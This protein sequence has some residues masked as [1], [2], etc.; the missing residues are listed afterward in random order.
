MAAVNPR[1]KL[2]GTKS[3]NAAQT[4]SAGVLVYLTDTKE[5]SMHDGSTPGGT[6]FRPTQC[7]PEG[8]LI[9]GIIAVAVA[10]NNLTVSIKTLAGNNP[11]AT[12]SVFVRIGTAIHEITAALSVTLA[13]G[14][15]W[16]G[17]GGTMFAGKTADLFV[18]LGYNAT[19][20]V[21]LGISR[22]PYATTYAEFSA[23]STAETYAG[24]STITH[25]ASTDSYCVVGRFAASL[26][27]SAT[28]YWTDG[29]TGTRGLIHRPIFETEVRTYTPTLSNFTIG[30][31]GNAAVTGTYRLSGK[32]VEIEASAVLGSSGQSV[33][34]GPTFTL[35][36]THADDASTYA[37]PGN[38][39]FNDTGASV[40][41]GVA[42]LASATTVSL[43]CINAASTSA[44]LAAVTSS[45]PMTWA[46]GDGF[47]AKL[48]TWI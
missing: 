6:I 18:Y 2:R 27:A 8:Y 34:T 47:Y 36:F 44:Y 37:Q 26:G 9:N 14:T 39:T 30:S 28:Y 25:A 21:T 10:S 48:R 1:Q 42:R 43:S 20:G 16:M 33:G 13:A 7:V 12:D 23:T 22:I 40:Y 4:L 46:A 15:N 31:G 11:S 17:L 35:P 19:D 3:Q 32:Q 29:S 38:L 24:I 41:M 5:V 45:L